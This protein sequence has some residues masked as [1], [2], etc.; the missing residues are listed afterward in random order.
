MNGEADLNGR[1]LMTV[2][3]QANLNSSP[4]PVEAWIDTGF[5]GDLVMARR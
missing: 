4:E 5:T 2:E 3:I 1:A